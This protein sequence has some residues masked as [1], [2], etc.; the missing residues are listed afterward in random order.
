MY[1]NIFLFL[2]YTSYDTKEVI[3]IFLHESLPEHEAEKKE[4]KQR[5]R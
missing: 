3:F 2:F 5:E 4:R 1:N